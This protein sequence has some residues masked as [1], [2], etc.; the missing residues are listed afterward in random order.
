[1]PR[2][3]SARSWECRN[4]ARCRGDTDYDPFVEVGSFT[5]VFITYGI[6]GSGSFS[7]V[8]TTF[9]V[10]SSGSFRFV[11][12]TFDISG[13]QLSTCQRGSIFSRRV[14]TLGRYLWISGDGIC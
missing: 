5:F 12:I 7:S 8:P 14:S 3:D 6:F 10:I 9:G 13:R 4:G 1:M 11:T 2:A